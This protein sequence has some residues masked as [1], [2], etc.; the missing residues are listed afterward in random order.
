MVQHFQPVNMRSGSA[1]V[2]AEFLV[3]ATQALSL[4][5]LRRLF[6]QALDLEGGLGFACYSVEEN[7]RNLLQASENMGS[8][9]VADPGNSSMLEFSITGWDE[10]PYLVEVLL[11]SRFFAD[12]RTANLRAMATLFLCRALVLL[13][14]GNEAVGPDLTRVERICLDFSNE[15]FCDL[16]VGEKLGLSA[17]AV[18]LHRHRAHEKLSQL[19]A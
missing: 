3:G 17:H 2:A 6:T 12:N 13:E 16:D 4:G 9:F 11:Q 7:A 10:S 1:P 14:A 8:S 15:G 19:E 18:Q 5:E